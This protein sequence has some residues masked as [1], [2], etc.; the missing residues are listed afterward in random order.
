MLITDHLNLTGDNPLVGPAPEGR[1]R[2]IDM[3]TAYDAGLRLLAEQAAQ[4]HAISLKHGVYAALRGPSYETPAEIRMLRVLGADAV[5]MSTVPEVIALRELEVRVAAMSLITN[6]AAGVS[7]APLDHAEVQ[8]AAERAAGSFG[9][10]LSTWIELI[11]AQG[12]S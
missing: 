8:L 3:T 11:A 2:F 4:R 10:L 7:N 1:K 6:L 5:G 9:D 12:A